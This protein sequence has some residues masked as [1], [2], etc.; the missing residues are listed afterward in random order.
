MQIEKQYTSNYVNYDRQREPIILSK[1]VSDIFLK[2]EH[3]GDVMAL[4]WFYYYTAKWQRTNQPRATKPYIR[5][6]L[7][8]SEAKF[9]KN[10]R[11]LLDLGLIQ[12]IR[13]ANSSTGKTEAWYIRVNFIWSMEEIKKLVSSQKMETEYKKPPPQKTTMMENRPPNALSTNNKNALSTNNSSYVSA[14]QTDEEDYSNNYVSNGKILRN[15]K[16]S[17]QKEKVVPF[18]TI[19]KDQF[20]TFY[21]HYPRKINKGKAKNAWNKLCNKPSKEKPTLQDLLKAVSNQSKTTRWQQ[22]TFIPHPSTWLNQTR[23]LD[24]VEAM[25]EKYPNYQNNQNK[26]MNGARTDGSVFKRV[27]KNAR[28]LS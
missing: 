5:E 11:I 10:K 12:N 16:P 8:W 17:K 26:P 24:E 25:N 13:K 27:T 28:I 4:Y 1:I 18:K 7:R 23:W 9:I 21:K 19:S 2:Q 14:K 3:P 6:A 15:K 22:S 20:E